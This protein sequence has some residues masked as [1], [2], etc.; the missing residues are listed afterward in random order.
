MR[1]VL[2]ILGGLVALIL[3][4]GLI[5]PANYEVS[6][7]KT[8][9]APVESVW[10][11]LA[12]FEKNY[13]WSPWMEKDPD[14]EINYEGES[15]TVGAKYTWSGNDEVGSGEQVITNVVENELVESRLKFLTPMESE[16]DAFIKISEAEEGSGSEVTWGFKGENGFMGRIFGLFMD[17]DAMIGPDFERGLNKLDSLVMNNPNPATTG[18]DIKTVEVEDRLFAGV[19]EVV[20]MDKMK[21]F[22]ET[23]FQSIFQAAGDK[24]TGMPSGLYFTWDEENQETEMAAAVPV[25]APVDGYETFEIAAG[26]ALVI[27]YLG[28]YEGLGDAHGAMDEYLKANKLEAK[29]PVIEEYIT[30]PST[31]PDTSKWLTKVTYYL[32]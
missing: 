27:D 7:T 4:L 24:V 2:Y 13:E 6:R 12:S 15:G 22:F 19:K 11:Y 23:N 14:A 18:M 20:S 8:I 25:S 28:A 16:S 10:P 26:K 5:G 3:L 32:K 9:D 29:S 1:I 30:D 17:M 31:E 21:S